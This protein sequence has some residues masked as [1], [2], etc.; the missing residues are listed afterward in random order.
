[1]VTP[2]SPL[3]TTSE[4]WKAKTPALQPVFR[5]RQ[6]LDRKD[7]NLPVKLALSAWLMTFV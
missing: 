5:F 4:A 6:E 2:T 3:E 1:M 7:Q